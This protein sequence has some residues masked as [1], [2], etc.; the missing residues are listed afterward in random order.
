MQNKFKKRCHNSQKKQRNESSSAVFAKSNRACNL[1]RTQAASANINRLS[2]AVN[3]SPYFSYIRLPSSV[4]SSVR[5]AD[6][7]SKG[8]ALAA[9]ITFS[10]VRTPPLSITI[11]KTKLFY[12]KSAD[13]ASFF[14]NFFKIICS[15]A[16]N[17]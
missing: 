11:I 1:S 14:W 4:W 7:N 5:M 15:D 16:N 6:L 8:Y 12:H 10:H 17:G 2:I 3:D 9:N 13:N